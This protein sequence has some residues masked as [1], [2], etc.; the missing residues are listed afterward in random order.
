M[1]CAR[2]FDFANVTR[3]HV[4]SQKTF[5]HKVFFSV[6]TTVNFNIMEKVKICDKL[7]LQDKH[8]KA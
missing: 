1:D 3:Q 4:L 2:S 6:E 7:N 8:R 5:Y